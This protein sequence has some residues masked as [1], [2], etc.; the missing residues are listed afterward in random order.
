MK[1]IT[2]ILI[3][4]ITFFVG[5]LFVVN[6]Y[7]SSEVVEINSQKIQSDIS[8]TPNQ[9]RFLRMEDIGTRG[10]FKSSGSKP[11]FGADCVWCVEIGDISIYHT[12][13]TPEQTSIIL[14]TYEES[15]Y[16]VEKGFQLNEKGQK[17]GE[18]CF[19]IYPDGASIF[20]TEGEKDYWVISA[21]SLQLVKEFESSEEFRLWKSVSGSNHQ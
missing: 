19:L 4:F 7:K 3:G 9:P 2:Y 20:W 5:I 14:K 17:I 12:S 10:M 15:K 21:P 16:L 13:Q 6:T 8:D 11:V 18:R 1:H